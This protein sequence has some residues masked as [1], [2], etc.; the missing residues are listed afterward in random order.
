M[1]LIYLNMVFFRNF[2]IFVCFMFFLTPS[3]FALVSEGRPGVPYFDMPL[4]LQKKVIENNKVVAVS[5]GFTD[6]KDNSDLCLNRMDVFGGLEKFRDLPE[7]KWVLVDFELQSVL[8]AEGFAGDADVSWVK[9]CPDVDTCIEWGQ[10]RGAD[11]EELQRRATV[12]RP[13][14][15]VKANLEDISQRLELG[16]K[17][18]KAARCR[19]CHDL[20]GTGPTYAPS[21]TWKRIKYTEGWLDK[22]LKNPYR[23]RPAMDNLMMLKYTSP[24]AVP[25][26][27]PAELA[28][29]ADYLEDAAVTSAPA[30]DQR[31]ELWEDYDCYGC[32]VKLYQA[33]PLV[34]QPTAIPDQTK[35]L[36]T[37]SVAMQSCLGCHPFGNLKTLNPLPPGHVNAFAPDLLLSFEKLN[38]DFLSSFLANPAYLVPA[39]RMPNLG[40]NDGQILE[41]RNTALHI[42]EA[43]DSGEITP[44]HTYYELEKQPRH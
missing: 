20:E 8:V 16:R 1:K 9:A 19:G 4:F 36:I 43:I 38:L 13:D 40:L 14:V 11:P 15:T 12:P 29:V 7:N 30:N 35:A 28:V 21:L 33:K 44:V 18:V 25:H 39:T 42:K 37:A 22:Y 2:F 34:F 26:L 32:H 17:L 41:M 24:N 10:E 3:A 31:L 5:L 6:P 27:Q 23:M